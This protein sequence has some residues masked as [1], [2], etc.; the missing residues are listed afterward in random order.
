MSYS[1]ATHWLSCS[2]YA[3]HYTVP[4]CTRTALHHTALHCVTL[5]C[6][7]GLFQLNLRVS[8]H[9]CLDRSGNMLQLKQCDPESSAQQWVIKGDKIGSGDGKLCLDTLGSTG[10]GKLG[11]YECHGESSQQWEFEG[12]GIIKNKVGGKC[13]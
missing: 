10:N 6:T 4:H 7:T 9:S 2:A 1:T 8:P 11:L 3:I 13:V 5:H 12:E